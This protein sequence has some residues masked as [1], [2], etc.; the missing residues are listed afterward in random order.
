M[1]RERHMSHFTLQNRMSIPLKELYTVLPFE[2]NA[3]SLMQELGSE[4]IDEGYLVVIGSHQKTTVDV[5]LDV[6]MPF[7]PFWSVSDAIH[8]GFVMG[9][10]TIN[11]DL[12]IVRFPN[13]E[14][15]KNNKFKNKNDGKMQLSN[16]ITILARRPRKE[17]SCG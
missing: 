10:T 12:A 2:L 13:L 6:V 16:S 7:T 9:G 11:M 4:I 5:C 15:N 1:S 3:K 8:S 14:K 17:E